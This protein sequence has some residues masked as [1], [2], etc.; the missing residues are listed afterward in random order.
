MPNSTTRD[1]TALAAKVGRYTERSRWLSKV[2]EYILD[3][4][5][6]P[7]VRE[8]LVELR[9]ELVAEGNLEELAEGGR[10]RDQSGRG[11]GLDGRC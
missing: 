5:T 1:V 4:D 10:G 6:H 9:R 11:G 3:P 8:A 7:K 2:S